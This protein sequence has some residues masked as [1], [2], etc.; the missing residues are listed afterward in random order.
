MGCNADTEERRATGIIFMLFVNDNTLAV[1]FKAMAGNRF[2]I[3]NPKKPQTDVEKI[4][5][6][7]NVKTPSKDCN[8]ESFRWKSA[9]SPD[10]SLVAGA[11]V[12][13]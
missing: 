5:G 13:F 1:A 2:G 3:L 10:L 6:E 11:L 7:L 4:N 9:E 8:T 12:I